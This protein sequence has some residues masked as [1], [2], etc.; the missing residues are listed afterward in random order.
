MI[1]LLIRIVCALLSASLGTNL[2][3]VSV[4]L[5]LGFILGPV[6][7]AIMVVYAAIKKC[8]KA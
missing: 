4:G 2:L 3:S 6:G 7:L 8:E 1:V 5:S